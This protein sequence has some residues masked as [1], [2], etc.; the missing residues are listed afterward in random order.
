LSIRVVSKVEHEEEEVGGAM[1]GERRRM[2]YTPFTM[3]MPG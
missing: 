3:R 1:M 2:D